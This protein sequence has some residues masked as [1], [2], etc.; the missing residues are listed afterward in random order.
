MA[1][2]IVA[3][4]PIYT[5]K[6]NGIVEMEL[7]CSLWYIISLKSPGSIKLKENNWIPRPTCLNWISVTGI[8][9]FVPFSI[10][11]T[12][13]SYNPGTRFPYWSCWWIK[14]STTENIWKCFVSTSQCSKHFE[15]TRNPARWT[16]ESVTTFT[17]TKGRKSIHQKFVKD[18]V[19]ISLCQTK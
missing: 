3:K 12:S 4:L 13:N 7:F 14:P 5:V 2:N 11:S 1:A 8:I 17:M 6:W 19:K 18:R 15:T 9:K 16:Y 10:T